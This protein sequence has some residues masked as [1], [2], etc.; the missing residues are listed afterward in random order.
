MKIKSMSGIVGLWCGFLAAGTWILP[1][2]VLFGSAA[3]VSGAGFVV[4]DEAWATAQS[5]EIL[6]MLATGGLDPEAHLCVSL[7]IDA[8]MVP[9]PILVQPSGAD[10][11]GGRV[12]ALRGS[13]SSILLDARSLAGESG[14]GFRVGIVEGVESGGA[15]SIL[16]MSVERN[17]QTSDLGWIVLRAFSGVTGALLAVARDRRPI[18]EGGTEVEEICR[19]WKTAGDQ[20]GNGTIDVPDIVAVTAHLHSPD[21]AAEADVTCDGEVTALDIVE[22]AIRAQSFTDAGQIILERLKAA[23]SVTELR[24]G[25]TG[26]YSDAHHWSSW[27]CWGVALWITAELAV[28]LA[29]IVACGV[30]SATATPAI[31]LCLLAVLCG[32]I[33]ILTSIIEHQLHCN[34]LVPEGEDLEQVDGIIDTIQL[35]TG[36]CA[37]LASGIAAVREL[38]ERG[39][40]IKAIFERI[41]RG[42]GLQL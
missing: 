19:S 2:G 30:I 26:G 36:I 29:G 39:G 32:I 10:G 18:D 12:I 15:K 6:D 37:A 1:M 35:L 42:Y 17:P 38:I 20:D 9:D 7:D 41:L 14:F 27:A 5:G 31:L 21:A 28:M 13:D 23:E 25:A 24:A 40:G 16:V 22:I 11:L 33:H 8:D 4:S 34:I 3:T